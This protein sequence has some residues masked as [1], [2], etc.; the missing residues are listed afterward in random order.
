MRDELSI[1]E[2]ELEAERVRWEAERQRLTEE[3]HADQ[4]QLEEYT[5]AEKWRA[6][7]EDDAD[8]VAYRQYATGVCVCCIQSHST[9]TRV[10]IPCSVM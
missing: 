1:S 4:E 7:D 10:V 6:E 2:L 5:D 9:P 8:D 3:R